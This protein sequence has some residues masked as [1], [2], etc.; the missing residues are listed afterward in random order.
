MRHRN[1]EIN[2]WGWPH[3]TS[4]AHGSLVRHKIKLFCG[5][6]CLVRHKI[7]LFLWRTV[8]G[9]PQNNF[10]WRIFGGAPQK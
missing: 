4:V 8:P 7:K 1:S 9:A 10:L 6:P 2:D 3:Q 5:A